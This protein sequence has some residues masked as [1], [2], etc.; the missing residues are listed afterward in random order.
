MGIVSEDP[1][2]IPGGEHVRDPFD[3][4]QPVNVK[5]SQVVT[6]RIS[7]CRGQ[8][9]CPHPRGQHDGRRWDPLPV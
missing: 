1:R 9:A 2:D 6:F 4:E 7:Q 5:P 8:G 3:T